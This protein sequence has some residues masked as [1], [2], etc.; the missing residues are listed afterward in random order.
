ME[1]WLDDINAPVWLQTGRWRRYFASG[2]EVLSQ[3]SSSMVANDKRHRQLRG[4]ASPRKHCQRRQGLLALVFFVT[5]TL[6]R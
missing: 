3:K 5:M 6:T 4:V 2:K 1:F